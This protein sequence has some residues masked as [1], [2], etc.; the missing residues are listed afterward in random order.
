MMGQQPPDECRDTDPSKEET[1]SD[2]ERVEAQKVLTAIFEGIKGR[3]PAT[4]RELTEWLAS[5][6]GVAATAFEATSLS[7]WGETGRA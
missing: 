6:E 5:P 1:M 3:Q 4:D 7:R 2:I